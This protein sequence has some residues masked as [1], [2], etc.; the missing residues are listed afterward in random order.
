MKR[1]DPREVVEIRITNH[2]RVG[3]DLNRIRAT[4]TNNRGIIENCRCGDLDQIPARTTQE[5]IATGERRI[6]KARNER[7]AER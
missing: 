6:A 3:D 7:A 1:L 5:R 2:L 4:A